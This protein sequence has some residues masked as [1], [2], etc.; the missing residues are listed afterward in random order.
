VGK[1]RGIGFDDGCKL[2]EHTNKEDAYSPTVAIEALILSCIIVGMENRD[3]ATVYIPGVFIQAYMDEVV[4]HLKLHEKMAKLLVQ[5]APS[6]YRMFVRIT[7][8]KPTLSVQLRKALH[9]TLRAEYLFWKRLSDQ[10]I[11]WHS[12]LNGYNPCVENK[13]ICKSQC[14]II[15]HVDDLKTECLTK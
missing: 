7:K 13:E 6:L 15:W 4:V 1:I 5:L 14:T 3:V 9:G 11:K 2:C 12:V 8:G 10:L